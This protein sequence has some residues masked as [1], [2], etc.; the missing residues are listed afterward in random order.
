[1]N[2]SKRKLCLGII[3][4][5]SILY[6][7]PVL[8]FSG[9]MRVEGVFEG[10]NVTGLTCFTGAGNYPTYEAI[11]YYII[12]ILMIIN[13]LTVGFLYIPI[14]VVIY[15]HNK[16]R[17]LASGRVSTFPPSSLTPCL[18]TN[19]VKAALK[20]FPGR[21]HSKKAKLTLT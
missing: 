9:N 20:T 21:G 12:F 1:M 16:L 18:T 3:V 6:S 10:E 7:A 5:F 15:R 14:G 19:P 17:K 13:I 8:L 11:Y 4:G 2:E